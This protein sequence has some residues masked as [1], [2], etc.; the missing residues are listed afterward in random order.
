MPL[1]RALSTLLHRRRTRRRFSS[2]V[3]AVL[4]DQVINNPNFSTPPLHREID[5]LLSLVKDDD[6]PEH[7]QR[8]LGKIVDAARTSGAFLEA[9][10]AS[11]AVIIFGAWERDAS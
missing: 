5:Y 11:L 4:V 8:R 2:Y 10:L 6:A 7:V 9:P 3:D 1:F